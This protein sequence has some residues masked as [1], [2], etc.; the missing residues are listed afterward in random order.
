MNI[1]LDEEHVVITYLITVIQPKVM[2]DVY[3]SLNS[4][5]YATIVYVITGKMWPIAHNG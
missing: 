3:W 4:Y 5:R 1:V 2:G